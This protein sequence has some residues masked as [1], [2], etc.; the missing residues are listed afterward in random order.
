MLPSHRRTNYTPTRSSPLRSSFSTAK[1]VR[2]ALSSSSVSPKL[3]MEKDLMSNFLPEPEHPRVKWRTA[4]T[5]TL[6]LF[7]AY[8]GWQAVMGPGEAVE[9]E[10]GLGWRGYEAVQWGMRTKAEEEG[11]LAEFGVDGGGTTEEWAYDGE[12]ETSSSSSESR[13]VATTT[14][15]SASPTA[16]SFSRLTASKVAK[17]LKKGSLSAYKWHA[18]LQNA[19]DIEE[20]TKTSKW[21][22]KTSSKAAPKAGRLIIVG[23]CCSPVRALLV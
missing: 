21:A 3:S 18:T 8:V 12:E 1:T 5:A 16:T 20:G 23:T 6:L 13:T 2:F 14:S 9:N 10:I 4:A 15:S 19:T 22:S 17:A 11:Q 7:A